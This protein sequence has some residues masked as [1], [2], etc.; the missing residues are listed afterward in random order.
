MDRHHANAGRK[1]MLR[2]APA[3]FFALLVVFELPPQGSAQTSDPLSLLKQAVEAM[4]GVD[5]LRDLQSLGIKGEVRHWE[6]EESYVAGGPPVFTDHSTFKIIWDVKNGMA[7]TD[8]DRAIQFPAITH[9]IYSEIV[10]PER[11][12][13]DV[14]GTELVINQSDLPPKG[15]QAMSGIRLAAH[16]RELERSSPLLF[17][18]A[19]NAPQ[20]LT[21]LPDQLLGDGAFHGGFGGIFPAVFLPAVAFADGGTTFTILFDRTTHLPRAIRTRDDDA[22]L[23]DS[24]YDLILSDWQTT[25]RVKIAR[26]LTYTLNNMHGG[27]MEY[28]EVVANPPIPDETFVFPP[29]ITGTAKPPSTNDVP[30]QWVL[31]RL[32]FNRFPDSDA[33]NFMPGGG[34]RLAEL[35]PNVQQVVG[36]SHNGLIVAMKDYLVIFD[37]PINEWQSRFTIDAAKTRYPGKPVKYLVLTHHH[38]DH[39]GGGRTYVAEGAAVIVPRPD[40]AFF[41]QVFSAPHMVI[42]DELQKH[43]KAAIVIEVADQMTLRD[44]GEEIRLYNITNP[45]VEGM[46]V[47]YMPK[48]DIL[49][50]TDMYSPARDK[51]KSPAAVNLY[52]TLKQLGIKPSRLAGGHGGSANYS[53]F[54]AIENLP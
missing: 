19:L 3:L 44:D 49:W 47:G 4:G 31:R 8:W 39:A 23:G 7:R 34:L 29:A 52:E 37:A 35:S 18:K 24:N 17:L 5:A 21:A 2:I 6:P 27:K 53:E 16:L 10:T 42:V 41:E 33:V 22:L 15:Q 11:G 32:N 26:S 46:L 25:G 12:Y 40:K 51:R 13:A 43:P 30:Y 1:P 36:G 14:A 50:V 28:T 20:R 45:H 38:T 54:E 9:D 48:D